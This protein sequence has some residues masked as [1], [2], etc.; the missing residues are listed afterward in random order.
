MRQLVEDNFCRALLSVGRPRRAAHTWSPTAR[1]TRSA[2]QPRAGGSNSP[3][4][5]ARTEY[6]GTADKFVWTLR[7][8]LNYFNAG[9]FP[10]AQNCPDDS[11]RLSHRSFRHKSITM[12]LQLLLSVR[13]KYETLDGLWGCNPRGLAAA[14]CAHE[15]TPR[16]N[17][18][19]RPGSRP[20]NIR[21][22][23]SCSWCRRCRNSRD[24]GVV[25]SLRPA[26]PVAR[27]DAPSQCP[28]RG[29]FHSLCDGRGRPH[30]LEIPRNGG[31]LRGPYR[32]PARRLRG[33][34]VRPYVG[35]ATF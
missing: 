4:H 28:Q 13:V 24:Q 27:F 35:R 22:A 23:G 20:W 31:L 26:R 32:G 25:Q 2:D 33:L 18:G 11:P 1:L 8:D 21:H 9:N 19:R 12:A 10:P 17:C 5:A 30:L 7:L 29:G 3:S 16:N 14:A 34:H 15:P 6:I